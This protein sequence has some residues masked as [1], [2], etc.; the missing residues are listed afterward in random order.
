MAPSRPTGRALSGIATALVAAVA[1]AGLAL[2]TIDARGQEATPRDRADLTLLQ[3][4]DVYVATPVDGGKA[5][6]LARVASLKKQLAQA[7]RNVVLMLAG[8]FLSPSVA[9]SIFRGRQ[10]V[11]GLNAAGLD[12]ATLGN[13]EFDFGVDV[14]LERMKEARWTW[15]VSNVQDEQTG[16]PIGGARPY[17]IRQYG[18]LNVGFLGL[19]LTG[20]EITPDKRRGVKMIDPFEA[21]ATYVP[22]LKREGA[23]VLIAL[24]H[25]DFADDRRLAERFPEIDVIIGG[26]EH[27][28]ITTF[29]NRTLI[30][31]AG[32]DARFVARLDLARPS[33]GAALERHFELVP[34]TDALPD[35]PDTGRVTA[36]YEAK[37][38]KELE[39]VVGATTTPLNAV[40]ES[41]RS[42]ESNLGNLIADA[43][44]VEVGADLT[45]VNA[46]TIRSNRVYPPGQ[47][48]RRDLLAIHPLGGVTCK[49]EVPGQIVLDALNHGVARIGESVGRFPQVSGVTFQI[50]PSAPA[51]N[52]VRSVEVD[53][54]PLD[55]R[56]P[57]T[58]AITD[59]MLKGGDGYTMFEAA[60]VLV[61]PEQGTLLIG[62]VEALIRQR[63]VVSP[64]IEDRIRITAS[65]TPVADKRPV[66]LDTDMGPDSVMGMLYL[67]KAPEVAVRAITIVHGIADVRAG[68]QNAV[69]ILELTGDR[70]VPVAAGRA[71]P[72]RG[73]RSFPAFLKGEANTLGGAK[74][75]QAT[76]RLRT[77]SA[78]DLIVAELEKTG[79][80]ITIVAM[81]P[82]TNVAAAIQKRPAVVKKIREIVVMGGAITVPGN[83]DRPFVGIKNSAAEWN[84]YVDPHAAEMVFAAGAPVRLLPLDAT[85][86]V[87]V[88]PA[89][90]DR[91]RKVP[92]DQ[93]SDLLLALLNGVSAQIEAG[94]YYF[95]DALAAVVAAH[96]DV[97]GSHESCVQIVTAEGPT[98]GQT[99][100][101]SEDCVRVRVAEEINRQVFED[102]LLKTILQ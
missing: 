42:A 50:D 58:V 84:F 4:N 97:T 10:M 72:L 22:I 40:A 41:V 23:D 70:S 38:G 47:L 67:L 37:L 45:I 69:R 8:D 65:V 5:G 49:V 9:S 89:F 82:L 33:A 59:Y 56:K 30:T 52:R 3:I 78:E 99:K 17:L 14:L 20:E 95:W 39:V 90:V 77:E 54:Q 63:G 26:H 64:G 6:G 21:A 86:T 35:D 57:Y 83:V 93:T 31:K 15:V 2:G 100:A 96:P 62:D 43:M 29:V 13:H 94:S 25:L 44:R 55:L 7:G 19:C 48:T 36:D 66:I 1:S 27:F 98:L 34:I 73:A 71:A 46:G 76:L 75:P 102:R 51:G 16:Q 24:T 80:P 11:E 32:G 74:L 87:P 88:T 60:K 91:L 53:G 85:H 12:V 18:R 61:T 79:D 81:G 101:T 68:A 92:R 28:P